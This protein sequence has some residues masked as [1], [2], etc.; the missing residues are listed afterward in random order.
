MNTTITPN[1]RSHV[2]A[3]TSTDLASRLR[4]SALHPGTWNEEATTAYLLEAATRLNGNT[5]FDPSAEVVDVE[6]WTDDTTG[7]LY[8][9]Q[10]GERYL[11]P[12]G[13]GPYG[14]EL[15]DEYDASAKLLEIYRDLDESDFK[16]VEFKATPSFCLHLVGPPDH[17][18]FDSCL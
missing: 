16:L 18:I 10:R 7:Q 8:W 6:I 14:L 11:H 15:D 1:T 9:T 13:E 3:L 4:R 2:R 17:P 5:S 12:A